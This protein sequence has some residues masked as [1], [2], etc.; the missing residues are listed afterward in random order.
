MDEFYFNLDFIFISFEVKNFVWF[1]EMLNFII[2]FL[3]TMDRFT[4]FHIFGESF[5]I[6]VLLIKDL[7]FD[8]LI[9]LAR[10]LKL[11]D[12]LL[13]QNDSAISE[14]KL[15]FHRRSK[16]K[17]TAICDYGENIIQI[18]FFF[19]AT[20]WR[21]TSPVKIINTCLLIQVMNSDQSIMC[22]SI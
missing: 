9:S 4:S 14:L 15:V 17:S 19:F 18:Q 20:I 22:H 21:D 11:N 3:L 13:F 16:I 7:V 6:S 2:F 1:V 5:K 12:I 10:P 8:K